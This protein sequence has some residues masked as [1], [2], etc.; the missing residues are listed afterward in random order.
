MRIVSLLP[1]ATE[2]ICG[3]GRGQDL[4]GVTHECDFPPRV[5]GLP[6][7]TNTLIP[8]DTSSREIDTLVRER[9]TKSRA[10]YTLDLPVLEALRPNLIV[11]QTLCQVCAVAEDEVRA[12]ACGLPGKPEVL[13]L[14]PERLEDVLRAIREVGWATGATRV[15]DAFVASLEARVERVAEGGARIR[16]RPRVLLLEWLDPPFSSGHWNPQLVRVAGGI[17]VLGR[18][19][20]RSRTVSW[21]EVIASGPEAVIVS[22]CGYDLERTVRDLPILESV[23]GWARTPAARSGRVYLV[24]GSQ[25]FSRPGPRLVDSLEILAHA[26][27]PTVHPA[28][29]AWSRAVRREPPAAGLCRSCRHRRD[30]SSRRGSRFVLCLRSRDDPAFPKYPELP[31]TRCSG[32]EL[33]A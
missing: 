6:A 12:A 11:T 25:Y 7:V 22:C 29:T 16:E 33:T 17:E 5:R 8:S 24:D 2:M 23:P 26:L 15:A 1:S 18:E 10:L 9:L 3:V 21:E 27:H 14:E 28:P 32:F 19:G 20:E 31:V 30:V 13:N 4:V